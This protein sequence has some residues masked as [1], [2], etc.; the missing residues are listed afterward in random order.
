MVGRTQFCTHVNVATPAGAAWAGAAGPPAPPFPLAAWWSKS[1]AG[2]GGD[3]AWLPKSVGCGGTRLPKSVDCGGGS[4]LN[5]VP[6]VIGPRKLWGGLLDPQMH[7]MLRAARRG[8]TVCEE[9]ER[10]PPG[11]ARCRPRPRGATCRARTGDTSAL[12]S[13]APARA[14]QL[15]VTAAGAA[16]GGAASRRLPSW[17][18]PRLLQT[19]QAALGGGPGTQ[20]QG[21]GD[22]AAF[23]LGD[24]EI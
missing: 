15:R 9:S 6:K 16:R 19:G 7:P 1:R 17:T 3:Q 13:G 22:A 8:G 23:G 2:G 18:S 24:T 10:P 12:R 4:G 11:P 5:C 20:E 21:H 14:P